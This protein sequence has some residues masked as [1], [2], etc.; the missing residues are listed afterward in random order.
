LLSV[1]SLGGAGNNILRLRVFLLFFLYPLRENLLEL[2]MGV[3]AFA[4]Q[5]AVH[6]I[7]GSFKSIVS[8]G[9]SKRFFVSHAITSCA[10]SF[11]PN[12]DPAAGSRGSGIDRL[13]HP[14]RAPKRLRRY[15]MRPAI[16]TEFASGSA[17]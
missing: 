15:L 16:S 3:N 7:H 13:P 14:L 17:L 6:R 1:G 10:G 2:L 11:L 9:D 12:G 4:D 8:A 5:Q